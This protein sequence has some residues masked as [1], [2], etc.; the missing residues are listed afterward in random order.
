MLKS[1]I[2][3]QKAGG[4]TVAYT[5][6]NH[7]PSIEDRKLRLKLIFEELTELAEAYG[8][9]KTFQELVQ[10]ELSIEECKDT[11]EFDKI[12][13]LDALCDLSVVVNGGYCVSGFTD[14]A[15]EAYEE[16]MRS[17]MSKFCY[18]LDEA[19]VTVA[20]KEDWTYK[21]VVVDDKIIYA[22]LRKEDGKIMKS[23]AF[24]KPDYSKF[25][26]KK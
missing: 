12:E 10:K 3:F 26:D 19:L 7:T 18:S 16:T 14:I 24:Y 15:E 9:E 5:T 6:E 23:P 20:N 2:E 1:I 4:H 17:N 11:K 25:F 21:Q 8:L 13:A 22:I